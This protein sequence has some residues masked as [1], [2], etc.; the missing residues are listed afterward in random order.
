MLLT[1]KIFAVREDLARPTDSATR[2]SLCNHD[3]RIEQEQAEAAEKDTK[4][5]FPHHDKN[6]PECPSDAIIL[7]V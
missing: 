6:R 2:K 4:S 1:F 7:S 5:G 3:F